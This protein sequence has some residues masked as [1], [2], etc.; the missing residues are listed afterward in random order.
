MEN[1]K[2]AHRWGVKGGLFEEVIFPLEHEREPAVPGAGEEHFRTRGSRRRGLASLRGWRKPVGLGRMWIPH[3]RPEAFRTCSHTGC[4]PAP[5]AGRLWTVS[6]QS[7]AVF[8]TWA[9]GRWWWLLINCSV[10]SN[11]LQPHGLQ[12]ARFPCPSPFPAICSN[13]GP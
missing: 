8:S 5:Q 6:D 4:V 3:L 10:V 11:S 12:H 2:G 7:P 9:H 13:S 1:D